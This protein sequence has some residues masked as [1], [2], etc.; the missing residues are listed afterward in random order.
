ME[1]LTIKKVFKEHGIDDLKVFGISES[2]YKIF[3]KEYG[4]NNKS[5][6]EN[7][8]HERGYKSKKEILNEAKSRFIEY[9]NSIQDSL[10]KYP[11]PHYIRPNKNVKIPHHM[12]F[13]DTEAFIKIE[14][15]KEIHTLRLGCINYIYLNNDK[16][17]YDFFYKFNT[18]EQ[19]WEI[20]EILLKRAR[21]YKTFYI[22]AHNW[23]YDFN[24]LGLYYLLQ[25]KG[26]K[27]TQFI[28]ES[29]I[30]ICKA[31]R[32]NIKLIFIDTMNYIKQS[33]EEIGKLFNLEK[34]DVDFNKV[35]NEKLYERCKRDVEIIKNFILY[36]IKFI[37]FHD[38]GNFKETIAGLSLNAFKH[39]FMKYAIHIHHDPE[40][41][42]I[43]TLSYRGGRVEMLRKGKFENVYY[44]DVN[45]MYPYVMK[46]FEYPIRLVK[47]VLGPTI[48][49]LKNYLK[50]YLV[51]AKV[52]IKTNENVFGIKQN[53]KLIFPIGN[54][55]A[56]L[57]T[58]EIQYAIDNN[59]IQEVYECILYEKA[60]IFKEYVEYFYNLK[61]K[62]SNEKNEIFK[63]FVKI[64]MNSLYGKF[65]QRNK[66]VIKINKDELGTELES[67]QEMTSIN[68]AT[69]KRIKIIRFGEDYIIYSKDIPSHDSFI[70]IASHVTAYARMYLWKIIK[71]AG[72]ENVYYC[73]TDSIIVNQ[74]GYEN[75]KKAALI[76]DKELGKLKLEK[77]GSIEIRNVKDYTFNNEIKRKGIK[78]NAIEIKQN[79]FVQKQ[80]LKTKTLLR[81]NVKD[82]VIVINQEKVLSQK[83]DKGI[84]EDNKIKPI[85]LS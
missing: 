36:L 6:L 85:I 76:N 29:D 44:L 39:R 4:I 2:S 82:S 60:P 81:K 15:D 80:F 47:Y 83:Y 56:Y 24:I 43:E 31:K 13:L 41:E 77:H 19:F 58:P 27:I 61:I 28:P 75:L 67:G 69:N 42:L 32:D 35:D 12:I 62:Y 79:T 38:L 25:E 55:E 3:L 66:K 50:N 68:L 57:V 18:K 10:I 5:D 17:V 22:L 1:Y 51:I 54:F 53:N 23:H 49:E 52:R 72:L 21:R 9:L 14:N 65:G 84:I 11:K 71:I 46:N 34:I 8:L 73:D 70:A 78:P 30:F 40:M 63:H 33:V 7:F 45:S 37:Q 74:E 20:I 16:I 64:F 59:L 48:N 26:F